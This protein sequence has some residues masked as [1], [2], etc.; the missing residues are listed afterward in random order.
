MSPGKRPTHRD[1]LHSIV[2]NRRNIFHKQTGIP[3][4]ADQRREPPSDLAPAIKPARTRPMPVGS[5]RIAIPHNTKASM[6]HNRVQQLASEALRLTTSLRHCTSRK[7]RA[8]GTQHSIHRR[9]SPQCW[10]VDT[11]HLRLPASNGA[12]MIAQ[13]KCH[14]AVVAYQPFLNNSILAAHAIS[15]SSEANTLT[16][17]GTQFRSPQVRGR[18]R[19]AMG[20]QIRSLS[21]ILPD[22][23]LT[24]KRAIRKGRKRSG[25]IR[26]H[27]P[28]TIHRSSHSVDAHIRRVVRRDQTDILLLPNAMSASQNVIHDVAVLSTKSGQALPAW[29]LRSKNVANIAATHIWNTTHRPMLSAPCDIVV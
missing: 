6:I 26:D 14:C 17:R 10:S 9:N 1:S 5:G 28:D 13:A 15:D 21:K 20:R 2:F 16:R 4:G 29:S 7:G 23:G 8:R 11:I 24:R 12:R 3:E 22:H 25:G 18:T 19:N 27:S